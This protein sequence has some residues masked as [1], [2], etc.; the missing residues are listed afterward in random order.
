MRFADRV[1]EMRASEIR[2]LLKFGKKPEI[3][4][5]AGGLPSPASFPVKKIEML[6]RKVF[7]EHGVDPFQYGPTEGIDEFR[8]T[9]ASR[10]AKFGISCTAENV[11]T[12]NGAQEALDL[13]T[14]IFVNPGDLVAVEVPTYLGGICT[15]RN[16]QSRFLTVG[17]DGMGMKTEELEGKLRNINPE[18]RERVKLIYAIPN[19]HNPAGVTMSLER[20]KQLAEIAETYDIPVIEDDPYS[21]LR[22]TG[23]ELPSIKSF[24][25]GGKVIYV[26]T[27]SKTFVPG[28]R[29]GWIVAESELAR[30]ITIAKQGTDLCTN[31]M[32]QYVANDYIKTGLM[33][34]QITKIRKMY[35]KKRNAMLRSIESHMPEGCNCVKPDGGMFLWMRVPGKID[36]K[37]MFMEG[38][39][40]KVCYVHGAAFCVDGSGHDAMRLNFSYETEERIEEGI[41]RLGKLIA[42]KLS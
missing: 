18:E 28:M 32:C 31:V 5:F 30:K 12:T 2:E 9:L 8:E 22:Y 23:R 20:R 1:N 29:M 27:L 3:I 13:I 10:M 36:T 39:Q 14:K 7:R 40:N 19:F 11:I 16:Y 35:K 24:D 15:F 42:S 33:D 37:E 38:I 17:M 34:K 6:C 41:K 21:E 4:S 26:G 25:K